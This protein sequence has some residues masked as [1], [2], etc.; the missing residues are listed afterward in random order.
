LALRTLITTIIF[1]PMFLKRLIFDIQLR[2][3]TGSQTSMR[4]RVGNNV[5]SRI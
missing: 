4:S 3:Q 2:R 5:P 1:I